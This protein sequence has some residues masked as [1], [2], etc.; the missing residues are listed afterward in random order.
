M[1]LLKVEYHTFGKF[2][3]YKTI[4]HLCRITRAKSRFRFNDVSIT[5]CS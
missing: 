5:I 2:L 1:L 4:Y 3:S